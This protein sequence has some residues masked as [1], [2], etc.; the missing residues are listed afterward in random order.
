MPDRSKQ[1][2]SR[3]E[4]ECVQ[5]HKDLEIRAERVPLSG[6]VEG[7]K[8]DIKVYLD[9]TKFTGECKVGANRFA[10]IYNY[11]AIETHQHGYCDASLLELRRNIPP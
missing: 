1:K 5:L 10:Q 9:Q 11:I 3:F 4:R 2:G 8:G 7:F 6:A